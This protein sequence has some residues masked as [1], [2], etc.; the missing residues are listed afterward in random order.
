M[1]GVERMAAAARRQAVDAT[2]VW[3]MRQA[4]RYLPEYRKL[5][6]KHSILTIARTPELSVEVSL[7]PVRRL[8]VDAAV[9]FA[10]IMLPLDGMGVPFYIEPDIG[11]IIPDP[12]RTQ[13]QVEAIRVVSAEDATP[14]VFETIRILR[15]ELGDSTA[16]IGFSGSPF[17]LACYMIEG[18][19]SRD[20]AQ[21]KALMFSHPHRWHLFMEKITEV[22]VRYLQGQVK[23]GIHVAQLF[24]SWVGALSPRHY[25]RFVL[26]YSQRI[27][28]EMRSLG[29][30]TIHFGTGA[31]SLLELMAAAGSDLMGVDWRVP[32]DQAWARIGY[33]RGIQGNLDPTV[34]LAPFEVIRENA[35]AILGQTGGRPGHIFN[36]GHGVL[37]GTDPD[38]LARLVE[39]VHAETMFPERQRVS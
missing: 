30:P 36:L 7:M 13:A 39:L 17:T 31:A 6:Q 9:I 33:D 2:P 10:D 23:A 20:Y 5:R 15:A 12:I 14:Y 37:P 26:P 21:A 27:F 38:D 25:E 11:P 28:E 3:F 19:P 34:M 8:Q 1:S 32:L 29:I 18:R 35:L 16:V 22:V 4:G 24:D